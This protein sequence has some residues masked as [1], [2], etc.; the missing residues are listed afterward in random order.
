MVFTVGVIGSIPVFNLKLPSGLK[1]KTKVNHWVKK[2]SFFM[3]E[4][5]SQ[6]K[7]PL[8][9]TWIT[10]PKVHHHAPKSS[11]LTAVYAASPPHT[12]RKIIAVGFYYKLLHGLQEMRADKWTLQYFSAP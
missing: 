10:I 5:L 9:E 11:E 12:N 1:R 7:R 8:V 4:S 3:V 6:P 2:S